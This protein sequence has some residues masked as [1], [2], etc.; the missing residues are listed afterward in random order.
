MVLEH[1]AKIMKDLYTAPYPLSELS[2]PSEL[3]DLINSP[4][5]TDQYLYI[6]MELL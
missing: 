2:P 3:C 5:S 1:I 6:Q 4:L